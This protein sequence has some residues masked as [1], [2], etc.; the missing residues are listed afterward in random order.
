MVITKTVW[1]DVLKVLKRHGIPYTTE[2]GT[3]DVNL[4][5]LHIQINLVIPDYWDDF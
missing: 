5:D 2:I 1:K 3:P 4:D